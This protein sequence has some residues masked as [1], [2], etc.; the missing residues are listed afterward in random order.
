EET[1]AT[2]MTLALKFL[3]DNPLALTKL[4]EEHMELKKLKTDC[5]NDYTW[6]DYMALPFT[7]NVSLQCQLSYT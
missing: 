6:T 4:M 7:Q 1:L 3:S 2:A 5:S